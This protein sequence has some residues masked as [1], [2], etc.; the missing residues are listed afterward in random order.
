MIVDELLPSWDVATEYSIVIDASAD[1]V[2]GNIQA[3]DMAQSWGIR[4]LFRLRGL[5][6]DALTIEGLQRTGFALLADVPPR[7]MVMGLIGRFWDVRQKPIATN[8]EH[9][10]AFS[11]PGYTKA[12]WNFAV[13]EKAGGGVMLSTHTRVSCTDAYSARSFRRYWTVVSPFSGWI[14]RRALR[15]IKESSERG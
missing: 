4:Q 1:V 11:E 15:I 3:L 9:F 12:V 8:A 7:E 13:N 5:P 6:A 2:Y 14:R 10:R